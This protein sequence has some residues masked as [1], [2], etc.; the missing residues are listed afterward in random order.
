MKSTITNSVSRLK[1]A[2][3]A[4]PTPTAAGAGEL[5]DVTLETKNTVVVLKAVLTDGSSEKECA[6]TKSELEV[7]LISHLKYKFTQYLTSSIVSKIN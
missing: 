5:R 4:R 1:T 7:S 6:L 3:I 2:T